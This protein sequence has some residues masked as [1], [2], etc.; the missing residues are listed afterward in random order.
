MNIWE[1]EA[2][3]E[4]RRAKIN[5]SAVARALSLQES[6]HFFQN[7]KKT[8]KL[9]NFDLKAILLRFEGELKHQL[10]FERARNS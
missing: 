2:C 3:T 7:S 10:I 1:E 4:C 8:V 9:R 6:A 5:K